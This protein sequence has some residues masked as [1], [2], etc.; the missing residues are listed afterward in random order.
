MNEPESL[1]TYGSVCSGIEAVTV[2]WRPLGFSPAWFADIDP[3]ANALLAHHYPHVP[4]LGDMTSIAP[5]ILRGDI[6]APDILI[7]GTPCQSF[8]IAGL[9]KGLRDPRGALTL[10]Y[11]ELAN[12]ID[13]TRTQRGQPATVIA[14]ENVPGILSDRGNAFGCFL[15]AL[16]GETRALQPPGQKWTNAGCVYGP[17]RT[18]AWRVLDAQHFGV[19][20]R[21]KRVFV[22]AS[23]REDLNPGAVLFESESVPGHSPPGAQARENIANTPA[24]GAAGAGRAVQGATPSYYGRTTLSASFGGGNTSG[25]IDLAACLT[26]NGQRNDFEHETFV[27]QAITGDVSHTLTAAHDATEDGNGR[28]VPIIAVKGQFPYDNFPATQSAPVTLAFAENSR[29]ELGLEGRDGQRVGTLSAGGGKTGQGVPTIASVALRGRK[30][31][32]VPELGGDLAPTLRASG[33]GSDKAH[34]LLPPLEAHFECIP[35]SA[36]KALQ[37]AY[38]T[39]RIRR[40]MPLECERLQGLPEHYTLV[41]YRG[42]PAADGPRYRAIGLSMAVPC[43]RWIGRRLIVTLRHAQ[44]SPACQRR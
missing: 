28:G 18:A 32:S 44:A 13:Q 7:G 39:W 31:G 35:P 42:Q 11:V 8:S 10:H 43:V 9:R 17:Q 6:C 24:P 5:Q 21:R 37:G 22:V 16:V 19:A 26:G 25:P 2:A 12:A 1:I 30:H 4:N 23:A 15:G 40:L 27:A 14:W 29:G 20:Q 34:V 38:A 36:S 41:P 33:G 3:F